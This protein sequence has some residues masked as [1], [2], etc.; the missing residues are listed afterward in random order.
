MFQI[1]MM[2][3]LDRGKR[4]LEQAIAKLCGAHRYPSVMHDIN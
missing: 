1:P 4:N 3:D 2:K